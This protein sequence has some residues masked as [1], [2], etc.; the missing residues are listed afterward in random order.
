[1]TATH[2]ETPPTAQQDIAFH[3]IITIQRDSGLTSS[4]AGIVHLTPGTGRDEALE[5]IA[6]HHFPGERPG[7]LVIL[8]FAIE[9]NQL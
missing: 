5:L 2:T 1:M 3:F 6:T 8:F 7:S 9:R 4:R